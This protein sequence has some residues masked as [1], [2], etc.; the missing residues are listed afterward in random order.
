VK[1]LALTLEGG[2]EGP[3]LAAEEEVNSPVGLVTAIWNH[4]PKMEK[5]FK[6]Q[7]IPWP[8]FAGTEMAD[9]VAYIIKAQHE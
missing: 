3:D 9:L 4:A 1:K 6:K 2:D 8:N 5:A 7:G